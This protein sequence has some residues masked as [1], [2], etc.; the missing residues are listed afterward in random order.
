MRKEISRKILV[1]AGI[2]VASIVLGY[3]LL[4]LVYCINIPKEKYDDTMQILAEEGYHP[5]E[6]LRTG[7]SDYFHEVYPDILDIGTDEYIFR[8]SLWNTDENCFNRALIKEYERYWHGYVVAL[9]PL[10][11]FFNLAE[12]R[13]INLGVQLFLFGTFAFLIYANAKKIRYVLV[14]FLIYFILGPNSLGCNMQFS[15]IYYVAII[16]GI[17]ALAFRRFWEVNGRYVYLFLLSG[18]LTVYI[19]FLTYPLLAWSVP[20]TVVISMYSLGG[21]N[22]DT[23]RNAQKRIVKLVLSATFWIAGYLIMWVGKWAIGMLAGNGNYWGL[24]TQEAKLIMSVNDN[25]LLVRLGSFFP[26]WRHLTYKP[27]VVIFATIFAVW[28]FLFLKKGLVKDERIPAFAIMLL[29][30]PAWYLMAYGHTGGHHFYTWRVTLATIMAALMIICLC[31]D[32]DDKRELLN[33]KSGG[34]RALLCVFS[35]VLGCLIYWV[36]PAETQENWNYNLA[37]TESVLMPEKDNCYTMS[38]IPMHSHVYKVSPLLNSDGSCGYMTM[39]LMDGDKILYSEEIVFDGTEETN[40]KTVP[41]NWSLKKGNQYQLV[42]STKNMENP[43]RTWIAEDTS[44]YE[45]DGDEAMGICYSYFTHFTNKKDSLF[46]S[47]AWAFA[48]MVVA[49]LVSFYAKQRE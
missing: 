7:K 36:I 13:L 38:F 29:S 47:M 45:F 46:Y 8:Y 18:I 32:Y 4:S 31:T 44:Q 37:H 21:E 28:A 30:A 26:N 48:L 17:A 16:S 15:S 5:R 11:I 3:L 41:V 22:T 19:D 42:F 24:A 2:L 34:C 10:A 6:L 49:Y 43:V 33:F 9:R 39:N 14:A 35:M 20:A 23:K 40:V 1:S 25:S 27:F 12:I